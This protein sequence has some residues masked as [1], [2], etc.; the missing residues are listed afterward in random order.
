MTPALSCATACWNSVL[1]KVRISVTMTSTP[2]VS[3][4]IASLAPKPGS[5]S[6][7]CRLLYRCSGWLKY[8]L[9]ALCIKR[10]WPLLVDISMADWQR[11]GSYCSHR[12]AGPIPRC[13]PGV[14]VRCV[15]VGHQAG[16]MHGALCKR[17]N[18]AW[19]L[20]SN[21]CCT[22]RVPWLQRRERS[23]VAFCH[24]AGPH[25]HK[26]RSAPRRNL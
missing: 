17:Y 13:G 11:T 25:E 8:A 6:L 24:R 1:M 2:G 9:L 10:H 3:R 15:R 16:G 4:E 22:R 26:G 20:F 23:E 7:L 14:L 21:L 5:S 12:D 18:E 19:Q